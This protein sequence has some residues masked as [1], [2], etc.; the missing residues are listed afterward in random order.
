MYDCRLCVPTRPLDVWSSCREDCANVP[1][2]FSDVKK[3]LELIKYGQNFHWYTK[4][5][6]SSLMESNSK[7][8]PYIVPYLHQRRPRKDKRK[9]E[10]ENKFI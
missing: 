5:T 3:F 7:L 10:N 4:A 8:R 2:E 1:T 6:L 9:K